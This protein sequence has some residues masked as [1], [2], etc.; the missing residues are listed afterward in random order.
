MWALSKENITER[1]E[2]EINAIYDIIRSD[3]P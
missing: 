2:D 3:L 1:S